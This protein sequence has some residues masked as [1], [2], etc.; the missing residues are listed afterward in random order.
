MKNVFILF[1]IIVSSAMGSGS[2]GG[3]GGGV[4]SGGG[5][6]AGGGT[7]SASS[8]P[9]GS[10]VGA[11]KTGVK[12]NKIDDLRS[13]IRKDIRENLFGAEN[14]S[15][16]KFYRETLK[17]KVA[18]LNSK[19]LQTLVD[20]S[21]VR[22]SELKK[23]NKKLGAI[24][25]DVVRSWSKN[26][27]YAHYMNLYNS[28]T[29]EV[30]TDH[31]PLKS[32]KDINNGDGPW[33]ERSFDVHGKK[34]SLND[35]EHI[36]VRGARDFDQ[37]N[38]HFGFNC[39]SIGCPSLLP[40]QFTEKNVEKLLEIAKKKFLKDRSKNHVDYDNKVIYLS[41]IFD[42]YKKDFEAGH[43]G[44]SSLGDFVKKNAAYLADSKKQKK[45]LES[46]SFSI[47]YSNYDW[48]LNDIKH[49]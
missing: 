44:I 39:A 9:S 10:A 5:G 48:R 38:V 34:T 1:S 8:M 15:Q 36:I 33:D 27:R 40:V 2:S 24:S 13:D 41:P 7:S 14:S 29:L 3:G 25:S 19:K 31:Y 45:M 20:Y 22:T 26:K 17:E 23:Y 30:V 35:I 42:W 43:R 47:K 49:K 6:S 11:T 18:W 32:I 37:P 16:K 12:I 28:L 4:S 46:E 21:K